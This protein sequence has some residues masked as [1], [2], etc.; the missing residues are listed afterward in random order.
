MKTVIIGVPFFGSFQNIMMLPPPSFELAT[1]WLLEVLWTPQKLPLLICQIQ[2][3]CILS[4]GLTF[5]IP[6]L[7]NRWQ[8]FLGGSE[9][10]LRV[11]WW[12]IKNLVGAAS[13]LFEMT[14]KL[15]PYS[16]IIGEYSAKKKYFFHGVWKSFPLF[17]TVNNPFITLGL[18]IYVWHIC[19]YHYCMNLW[20]PVSMSVF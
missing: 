18:T 5:D 19:H 14:K 3:C 13:W 1:N 9:A 8:R 10:L 4:L 17:F 15:Y 20:N 6:G 2:K 12:P 7:A 16:Y 11:S